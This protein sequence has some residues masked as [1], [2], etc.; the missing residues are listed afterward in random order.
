MTLPYAIELYNSVKRGNA[1]IADITDRC[2]NWRRTIRRIG[3]YWQA[4]F[5]YSG[6]RGDLDDLFFDGIMR[7]VR[8]TSSGFVNWQGFIGDMA[9]QRGGVTWRRSIHE[10]NNAIKCQYTRQFA[11]VLTNGSAESGAWASYAGATVTQSTAWASDGTYSCKI[12]AGGAVIQGATIQTGIPISAETAYSLIITLNVISGT[13]RTYIYPDGDPA[14]KIAGKTTSVAGVQK[15]EIQIPD[16]ST[17]TG[18][19]TIGVRNGSEGGAGIPFAGTVYCDAAVFSQQPSAADTGWITDDASVSEYGR[20]ETIMLEGA[21]SADAAAAKVAT[22]LNREA[23]PRLLAPEDYATTETA[24]D[25]LTVT[26]YGYVFTLPWRINTIYTEQAASVLVGN[27]ISGLD[28]VAA[29]TVSPNTLSFA[30]DNRY[31]LSVWQVLKTL[32]NSGDAS[33]NLWALGMTANRE[34]R[35]EP[36]SSTIAYTYRGGKLYNAAGGEMEAWLAVP[37]WCLLDDAPLLPY[38]TTTAIDDPRRS[39][40]EEVEFTAPDILRFRSKVID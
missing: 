2:A 11:N 13:W 20:L 18:N 12:V 30:P 9:Y 21:M 10:V 8:E 22:A 17:F 23:F 25:K 38:M 15:I 24:E 40:I 35:Y 1:F 14:N 6:D 28:Y 34:L 31:Q 29:S 37:G 32:V 33:G 27:L 36:F 26:C 4:S 7:E 19:V 39:I 5:D 3:G 16:T